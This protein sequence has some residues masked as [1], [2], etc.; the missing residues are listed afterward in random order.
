MTADPSYRC[1]EYIGLCKPIDGRPEK[2]VML[3]VSKFDIVEFFG[4][5]GDKLCP[6]GGCILATISRTRVALGNFCELL[7]LLSSPIISLGR[8][9]M[10][11]NSCVRG[12]LLH[13]SECWALWREDIEHLLRNKWAMLRW[14]CGVKGKKHIS[15]YNM[16]THL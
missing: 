15:L 11:F 14:M 7:P 8:R 9:E 2:Y 5:V 16:Y 12:S 13:Q 6:G 3:E 1:K 4:Y 10:L